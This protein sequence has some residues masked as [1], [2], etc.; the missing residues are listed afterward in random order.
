MAIMDRYIVVIDG[1]T[2][3]LWKKDGAYLGSFNSSKLLGGDLNCARLAV[4]NGN[5]LAI[6]AYVRNAKTGLI[7]LKIFRLIFPEAQ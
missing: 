3:K 6:L 4:I 5:D 1:F 2:L 7:D